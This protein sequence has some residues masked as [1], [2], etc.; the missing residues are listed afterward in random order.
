MADRKHISTETKLRLFSEA[1]GHCQR[2]ECL[3]PLY[4]AEMGGDKHIAEMAHVIPHGEMGPRHEERPAGEFEAD[5]F[6]NLIL[7]C[8]TCHT[9]IDKDP[10]GYSRGTLLGWKSDHLAALANKQGIRAYD[11]RRQV[12]DAVIAA[13]AENKAVWEEFAPSDRS[14]FEYNPESEAAMT[15]V[16][17]MRGVILPN[18]FRILAIGKANQR[19]MTEGERQTFAR[20][21]EHVRGL[22]ERHVCG[23]A[24]GAI[25]Y[26]AE[27]DGIFA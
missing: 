12:R 24:G 4:P 7:L 15:W 5:S 9:I 20:Y 17:R 21:Q 23:V 10:D 27:M 18:H 2:R 1:A 3:Q 8:P 19:H 16:Q 14:N 11:E 25:R 13:M 26:P 6:E 22:S